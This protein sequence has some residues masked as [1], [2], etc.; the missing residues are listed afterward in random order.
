MPVSEYFKGHGTEVMANMQKQY[1]GKKGKSVFYATANKKGQTAGKKGKHGA[2]LK[3]NVAMNLIK[4]HA[5]K[6]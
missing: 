1:G 3:H 6:K 4:K 2:G 5:G